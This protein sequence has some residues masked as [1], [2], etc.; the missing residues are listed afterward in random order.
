ME[1]EHIN[2]HLTE[3]DKK[4][5]THFEKFVTD[6][7]EKADELAGKGAMLGEGFMAQTRAKTVQQERVG[8]CA[9]L[10]YAASFHCLVEE[11]KDCEELKPQPKEKWAS[12]DKK[13]EETKHRTEWCA[14][15]EKYRCMRCERGSKYM[16]MKGKCTRQK[17]LSIFWKLWKATFGRPRFGKKSGQAG[18]MLGLCERENGTKIDEQLQAGASRHKRVQQDVTTNPDSRR[19]QGSCQRG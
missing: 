14:E 18:W 6:G 5:M 2:A 12:V 3:K 13:R 4:E 1:V 10:Q 19:R 16:K 17:H 8:V 11:W 15:A 7:N 9:A